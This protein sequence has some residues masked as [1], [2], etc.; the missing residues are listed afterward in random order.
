MMM[1][2]EHLFC[3]VSQRAG[4]F[5]TEQEEAQGRSYNIRK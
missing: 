5:Q 3:E 1:G 4:A 2:Q